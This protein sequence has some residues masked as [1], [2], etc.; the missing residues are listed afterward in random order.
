M[1]LPISIHVR[2][3]DLERADIRSAVRRTYDHLRTVDAVF[4]TW[5][6]DS[7]L[8]RVRRGTLHPRDAHPW[9]G[10][11]RTL[12]EEASAATD[13]RFT[14]DL[15]GPDGTRGWDPTGLVKGWGVREAAQHLSAVAGVRFCVNAG[16]DL[17]CGGGPRSDA[18]DATWRVGLEDPVDPQHITRV[19]ALTDGALATSGT[20]ARGQHIVD[21]ATAR[22]VETDL[23]SI[24]ITGPDLMWADVWA[25]ASFVD[26][27]L[28]A[29]HPDPR[30]QEYEIVGRTPQNP[31]A[32]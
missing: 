7:D 20:G 10:E 9:V 2:A 19:V 8:L 32:G 11:V 26:P 6:D 28:L 16:G 27:G 3:Q 18:I 13:G 17:V 15:V 12:C 23:T 25:T 30:W 1:G 4:S 31:A 29:S 14:T 24:S 5:R 22:P 21:P